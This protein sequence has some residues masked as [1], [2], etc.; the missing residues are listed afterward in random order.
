MKRISKTLIV[1]IAIVA[2]LCACSIFND[3]IA[4]AEESQMTVQGKCYEEDPIRN[5]VIDSIFS[6]P[7]TIDESKEVS[8][9]SYGKTSAGSLCI[10]GTEEIVKSTYENVDA[11]GVTGN[12]AFS[13]SFSPTVISESANRWHIVNDEA[14]KVNGKKLGNKILMGALLVQKK[15]AKDEEYTDAANPVLNFFETSPSGKIFYQTSGADISEGTYYRIILAYETRLKNG[16]ESWVDKRNTEVYEFYV[17]ENSGTI[18]IHNLSTD[19]EIF[20]QTEY[21]QEAL[22]HGETL[23]NGSVTRDGFKIE[24]FASSYKITVKHNQENPIEI[25]RG[26]EFTEDGEYVIY[27]TT[28]LNKT[29]ATNIYVFKGGNDKGYKTYFGDNFVQAERVFRDDTYPTYARGGRIHINSLNASVPSLYGTVV[30]LETNK[31]QYEFYGT[32]SEQSYP[33]EPGIYRADLYNGDPDVPGS[34]YHYRFVFHILNENSAPYVNYNNLMHT[35]GLQDLATKHYEVAYQ[36]TRGGYIYVCFPLDSREKALAYAREIEGRYIEKSEDNGFYYKSE[37]N[38]NRKIKYYDQLELTRVSNY[39]AEQNVEINYFDATDNFTYRTYDDDL[40]KNLEQ[41]NVT[42]SIKVFPSQEEKQKLIDRAPFLNNFT[43]IQATD[44]DVT[45]VNAVCDATKE[46]KQITI[47]TPVDKQLDISSLYHITETNK[48]GKTRNYDAYYLNKCQTQVN[49]N[50]IKG[51]DTQNLLISHGRFADDMKTIDADAV[52]VNRAE[53]IYD[54]WAIIT[55]KAPNVYSV[56][57][58]C[59]VSEFKDFAFTKPGFYELSM[60]DRIGNHYEIAFNISGKDNSLSEKSIKSYAEFY[61]TI[62]KKP[63]DLREDTTALSVLK[64]EKEE[65]EQ[66]SQD[67]IEEVSH[68]EIVIFNISSDLLLSDVEPVD[69][70]IDNKNQQFIDKKSLFLICLIAIPSFIVI[71]ILL[72]A[73]RRKNAKENAEELKTDVANKEEDRDED[74]N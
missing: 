46:S 3:N 9:F 61:N 12:V 70:E 35:E 74:E 59:L 15:H 45:T 44:Y 32:R 62:Y 22:K 73:F 5:T 66:T 2:T 13:Y 24:S 7:Y 27:V 52:Y 64:E 63:I 49:L 20:N 54:P 72:I 50:V 28:K 6:K 55:V 36:T 41:I 37:N 34:T 53:N 68:N 11:Y 67:T 65:Q 4:C 56:E 1:L 29:K 48:Y 69:T 38:P 39:Y 40:L 19:E 30:N 58:K 16:I 26:R 17:V 31:E 71:I 10:I 42:D 51:R 47:G 60:K 14:K 43:F 57:L 21:S 25:K 23:E 33:L 8:Q 18:A